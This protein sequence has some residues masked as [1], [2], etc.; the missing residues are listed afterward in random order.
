MEPAACAE[1]Y[2]WNTTRL[3]AKRASVTVRVGRVMGRTNGQAWLPGA[4]R[5]VEGMGKLP[6]G[7]GKGMP[8]AGGRG[9]A[10]AFSGCFTWRPRHRCRQLVGS[11]AQNTTP[12]VSSP[13]H[14]PSGSS[15]SYHRSAGSSVWCTAVS[16]VLSKALASA[17]SS[18]AKCGVELAGEP[19]MA[20]TPCSKSLN[21][22]GVANSLLASASWLAV[23][24][25]SLQQQN[26]T[27]TTQKVTSRCSPL[28]HHITHLQLSV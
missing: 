24:R 13:R 26:N 15:R 5:H 11:N 9:G 8:P 25:V 4:S 10:A 21:K 17:G 7:T 27:T 22:C 2:R 23:G 12:Q 16:R 6:S 18:G 1:E 19:T 3:T 14:L 20:Y 28:R